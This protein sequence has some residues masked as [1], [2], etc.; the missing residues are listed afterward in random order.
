MDFEPLKIG[1]ATRYSRPAKPVYVSPIPQFSQV[2][3]KV[4]AGGLQR[5]VCMNYPLATLLKYSDRAKA[6]LPDIAKATKPNEKLVWTIAFTNF[7]H[8]VEIGGVTHVLDFLKTLPAHA[9]IR[10][11]P[12]IQNT[13][14]VDFHMGHYIRIY[15]ATFEMKLTAPLN[16]QWRMRKWIS[17]TCWDECLSSFEFDE[18]W[19]LFP[20]KDANLFRHAITSVNKFIRSGEAPMEFNDLRTAKPELAHELRRV[21]PVQPTPAVQ[22]TQQ[23]A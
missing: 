23:T 7:H 5:E 12:Q 20:Q 1:S 22:G 9:E 6:E 13:L 18:I 8:G 2:D 4:S 16:D 10:G 14:P 3:I 15:E 11:K 19:N 21:R 17:A